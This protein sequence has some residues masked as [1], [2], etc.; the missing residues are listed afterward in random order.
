MIIKTD[1]GDVQE[2]TEEITRCSKP[3][4]GELLQCAMTNRGT[5]HWEVPPPNIHCTTS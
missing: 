2:R 1:E 4:D 3:E 5:T